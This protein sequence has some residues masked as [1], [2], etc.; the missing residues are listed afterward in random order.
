MGRQAPIPPR[1]HT[2]TERRETLEAYKAYVASEAFPLLADFVSK[3]E[4][5]LKYHVTQH[6]MQDWP[7]MRDTTELLNAKSEAYLVKRALV[8]GPGGNTPMSIF[9]LKQPRYG[10]TDKSQQDITSNNERVIFVNS[11]PRPTNHPTRPSN[12]EKRKKQG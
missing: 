4:T 11:V 7:E 5:A 1:R 2:P 10:Y 3:D 9:L 6:N 8:G 12:V